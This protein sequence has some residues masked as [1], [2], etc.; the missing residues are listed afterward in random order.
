MTSAYYNPNNRND[1]RVGS[2]YRTNTQTPADNMLRPQ[3][4]Y[5]A[6]ASEQ[7]AIR[8]FQY[9]LIADN[10]P[11][12]LQ[13]APALG[14]PKE[15]RAPYYK[16]DNSPYKDRSNFGNTNIQGRPIWRPTPAAPSSLWNP[17]YQNKR[18]SSN[19]TDYLY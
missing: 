9:G 4:A 7:G 19:S 16:Y 6:F 3:P 15:P 11:F 10:L 13:M 2:P 18:P 8:Q 5:F 12:L 17:G 14:I 1:Y